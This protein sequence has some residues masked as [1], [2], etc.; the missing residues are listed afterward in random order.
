MTM[1]KI[2]KFP[3]E[4]AYTEASQSKKMMGGRVLYSEKWQI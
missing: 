4:N 3:R 2:S 1:I